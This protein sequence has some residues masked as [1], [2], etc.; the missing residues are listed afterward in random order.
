[1]K[2]LSIRCFAFVL[3]LGFTSLQ[4][5]Q[6]R[7]IDPDAVFKTHVV[8]LGPVARG[9]AATPAAVQPATSATFSGVKPLLF[10]TF[11]RAPLSA[12][13]STTESSP[14]KAA[15]PSVVTDIGKYLNR[16]WGTRKK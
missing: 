9:Q 10:F 4:A 1:M 5:Q 12:R 11:T 14:A 15:A 7:P 13:N 6:G 3:V 16:H 2:Q 8:H